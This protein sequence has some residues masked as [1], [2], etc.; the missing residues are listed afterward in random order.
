MAPPAPADDLPTLA[1]ELHQL[2]FA[3]DELKE[4]HGSEILQRIEAPLQEV[5]LKILSLRLA[6]AHARKAVA[7]AHIAASRLCL[8]VGD[9]A[10]PT[11]M[12]GQPQ[13]TDAAG[14]TYLV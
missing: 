9:A 2:D 7:D 5:T 14:G 11:A 13:D 1:L 4:R 10:G 12:A 8:G 6:I 3:F